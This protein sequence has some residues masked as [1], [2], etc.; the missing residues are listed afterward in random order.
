MPDTAGIVEIER[1]SGMLM[2]MESGMVGIDT[3]RRI[4][5]DT[6]MEPAQSPW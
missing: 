4:G 1:G 5:T 6:G 3:G 2:R